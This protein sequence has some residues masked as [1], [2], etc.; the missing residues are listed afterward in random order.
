MIKGYVPRR[1]SEPVSEGRYRWGAAVGAG[2]IAGGVFLIV[3]R[4]NP[5]SA[6]TFFAPVVLGRYVPGVAGVPL[7]LVW[8]T[9]LAVSVLYGLVIARVAAG[10]RQPKAI[11]AGGLTGLVLYGLNFGIVT[12]SLPA[13]RGNEVG[14]AFTHLVFGLIAAGAYRGLLPRRPAEVPE[15]PRGPLQA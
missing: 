1:L 3:P 15:H 8:L 5:W 14:V 2:L 11:L 7:L 13:L 6:L 12:L 9:H 10:L 4:G